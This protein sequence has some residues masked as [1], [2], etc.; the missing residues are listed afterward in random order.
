MMASDRFGM[1]WRSS[2]APSTLSR[3]WARKAV[4]HPTRTDFGHGHDA[5]D[6][7]HR[8]RDASDGTG[9][10]GI[11]QALARAPCRLVTDDHYG[12]SDH[13]AHHG[14]CRP[15]VTS[16]ATSRRSQLSQGVPRARPENL[17]GSKALAGPWQG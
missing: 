11:E 13:Q 6:R 16:E 2:W 14:V 12:G 17:G 3:T 4:C 15:Q 1:W 7:R 8:C 10:D 5:I 9:F